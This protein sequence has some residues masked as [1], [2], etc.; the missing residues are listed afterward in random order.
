MT[1]RERRAARAERLRSWADSRE[2]KAQ[3]SYVAASEYIENVPLGQPILVGHHSERRARRDH[4]RFNTSMR[5]SLGHTAKAEEMRSKA[6]NI[7]A[8]AE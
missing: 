6:A 5:T 3:A 2:G 8:A 7:E 1:Y 4:A